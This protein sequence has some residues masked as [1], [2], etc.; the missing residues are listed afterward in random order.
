MAWSRARNVGRH[1]DRYIS[2]AAQLYGHA[3]RPALQAAGVDTRQADAHLSAGYS[4][5]NLL[6]AQTE[7][8]VRV[9]D[10]I[11]AHVRGGFE[12]RP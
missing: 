7:A 5:Y 11:A 1:A 3:L 6:K 10:G 4:S 2:L 12:Y 9:A 8:G